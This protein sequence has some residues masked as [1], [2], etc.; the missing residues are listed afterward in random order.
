MRCISTVIEMHYLTF[1][2][3]IKC[4]SNILEAS[5]NEDAL[6]IGIKTDVG[7][8]AEVKSICHNHENRRGFGCG[9]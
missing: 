1:L 8:I 4:G 9:N 7:W 5:K 6:V 2:M 3:M